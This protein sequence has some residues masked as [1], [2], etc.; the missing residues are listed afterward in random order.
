M[1]GGAKAD[2]I[3]RVATTIVTAIA[4]MMN[5]RGNALRLPCWEDV[6]GRTFA[7]VEAGRGQAPPL[8]ITDGLAGM[9]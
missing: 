9:C 2:A 8:P 1:C 3:N 4:V 6:I 5:G 7:G